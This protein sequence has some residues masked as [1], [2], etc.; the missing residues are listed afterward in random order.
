MRSPQEVCVFVKCSLACASGWYEMKSLPY[1]P[2]AQAREHLPRNPSE[3]PLTITIRPCDVK[4]A[5]RCVPKSIHFAARSTYHKLIQRRWIDV[6]NSD[7][8]FIAR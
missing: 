5:W 8:R 7:C 2:E 4:P 1:Q 6:V 3:G